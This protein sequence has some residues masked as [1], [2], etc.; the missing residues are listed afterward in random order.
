[1]KTKWEI[2]YYEATD[3]KCPI[4]DFIDSRSKRNQAKILS[5]FN[6]LIISLIDS[7]DMI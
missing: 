7:N 5:L 6:Y 3:G 2:I 1:M 4:N